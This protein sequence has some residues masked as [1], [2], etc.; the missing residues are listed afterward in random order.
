MNAPQFKKFSGST[1]IASYNGERG[2][3]MMLS[4]YF[5]EVSMPKENKFQA[6]LIKELKSIFPGC[7]VLKNDANYK[8]GIPD[9]TIFYNN[10]WAVLECKKDAK[11]KY[12]PN[13]KYYIDKMNEMSF[14]RAI[15]PEN[16]Q[17]VLNELQQAF[18]P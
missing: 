1:K 6:D 7:I 13:Q 12:R 17:E 5:L 16:K 18:R 15:Y 11:A 2:C 9:L 8:Q 10:K 14:A 3:R 4:L